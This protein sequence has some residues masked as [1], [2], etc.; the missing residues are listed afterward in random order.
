MNSDSDILLTY[1]TSDGNS[2]T[3]YADGTY[4]CATFSEGE[5]PSLWQISDIGHLSFKHAGMPKFARWQDD[6]S[7]GNTNDYITLADMLAKA[8]I[9]RSLL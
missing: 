5:P 8:A 3:F 2:I 7:S 6:S 9:E 4:Y 1:N